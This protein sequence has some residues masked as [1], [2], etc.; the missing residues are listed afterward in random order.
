[1]RG[2]LMKSSPSIF[3][4]WQQRWVEL[5]DRK[6]SYFKDQKAKFPSGVLNFEHFMCSVST[7]KKDSCC[8]SLRLAGNDRLFE[9]KAPSPESRDEWVKELQFHISISQGYLNQKMSDNHRKPWRFD[10]ISESQFKMQADTGDILLFRGSQAGSMV[11][12]TLTGSH[13]DHVAMVLK[14]ENDPDEVYLVEATGNMGVSLNR[15]LFLRDHIGKGK[16]Y[17]KVVF[18]HINFDRG[19]K[20]VE[21]L[22]QFLSEAVGLKYGIG[23]QKLIK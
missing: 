23:A 16:F 17:R 15:W 19:D 20:M 9:F 21:S 10:T 13:F 14:F 8:F 12:R 7:S 3:K 2:L 18:R 1:M 6:L 4:G 11:T 5:K 22:E